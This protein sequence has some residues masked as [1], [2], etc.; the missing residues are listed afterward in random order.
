MR[1]FLGCGDGVG[2]GELLLQCLVGVEGGGE[3]RRGGSGYAGK[4]VLDPMLIFQH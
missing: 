3:G 4:L 1:R 2:V